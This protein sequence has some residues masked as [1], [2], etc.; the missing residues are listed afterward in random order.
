MQA[1]AWTRDKTAGTG[2]APAN[3]FGKVYTP[4]ELAELRRSYC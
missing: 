3:P 2:G 1:A 4:K